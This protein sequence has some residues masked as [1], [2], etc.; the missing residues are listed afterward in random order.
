MRCI[1][2]DSSVRAGELF[3]EAC[4]LNQLKTKN[5]DGVSVHIPP[6]KG[7]M[8]TPKQPQKVVQQT[9]VQPEEKQK[10]G[11]KYALVL[12]TLL[13]I[14]AIGTMLWQYGNYRKEQAGLIAW[15]AELDDRER[16]ML[17]LQERIETLEK[18]QSELEKKIA[19][20]E[21]KIA[22]LEKQLSGSQSDQSQSQYDLTVKQAELDQLKLD[23]TRLQEEAASLQEEIDSLLVEQEALLSTQE[24]L[25]TA[26]E[27]A[28]I[29]RKKA[30]FMDSY[31]VF[32]ENNNTGYYHTYDCEAFAKKSFWAYSRKLAE[33][34]GFK[35]CPDCGG[36]P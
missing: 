22:E 31:V 30:Q 32:V 20:R 13:L 17:E 11:S 25:K 21:L 24:D 7:R 28:E 19:D 8:Q 3:C 33:S 23:N 10:K 6:A 9:V 27:G 4:A 1:K 26:L 5:D 29:Y 2:C 14:A 18:S 12:M 34:N 35:P 15:E 36:T 16:G